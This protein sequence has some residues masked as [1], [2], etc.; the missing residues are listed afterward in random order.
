MRN[1]VLPGW[2][3]KKRTMFAMGNARKK[4]MTRKKVVRKNNNDTKRHTMGGEKKMIGHRNKEVA[5]RGGNKPGKNRKYSLVRER[6]K[7]WR[8]ERLRHVIKGESG[9][10]GE[11][12]S[13]PVNGGW[14]GKKDQKVGKARLDRGKRGGC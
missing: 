8:R 9:K 5:G 7:N 10:G 4:T 1:K 11:R 2:G 14:G 13:S 3:E 6:M 12:T